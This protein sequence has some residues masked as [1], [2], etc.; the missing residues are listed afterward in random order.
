MILENGTGQVLAV[1]ANYKSYWT[2]PGG[3]IDPGETPKEAALR[4]TLEEVGIDVHPEAANFVAVVDRM[5]DR[6]QTYQFIFRAPLAA[7][8]LDHVVL[9]ASEIDE[10]ALV[11]KEQVLS[12]DRHYAK[13][14][15]AWAR[16]TTGYIEQAFNG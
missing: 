15:V 16:G 1:K 9:Q 14:L 7:A 11:T 4:E 3:I 8:M 10:Y 5:S 6:A 2:L 13:A 12:G